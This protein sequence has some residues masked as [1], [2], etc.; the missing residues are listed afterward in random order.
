VDA[1]TNFAEV[2][3]GFMDNVPYRQ[4]ADYIQDL[5]REQG[6][7]DG[8][9]LELGCGTGSLTEL[10]AGKGY[11]MIGV[12]N[13]GDMLQIAMEKREVSGSDILYLLQDM[14]EFEL[15]G[16]VRAVVSICDSM[17][18][19]TEYEDLVQ[20]LRLVN[21]YLDPEGILIFDLNTEYKYR[22]VLGDNTI[23]ECREDKSFI[24]DNHYDNETGINQYD[25]TLFICQQGD[26]Y[27]RFDETHYQRAYGMEEIRRAVC[28]AGLEL[29]AMYDAFSREPIKEDSERVYVIAREHGKERMR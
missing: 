9:V 13:S 17:N 4:W 14:R 21:N 12:D 19:I 23:A 2:Y 29:V 25:L 15:Y 22:Q 7:R 6:I 1:Y 3:D 20:V 5:L 16:T 10:L 8:L 27:R 24:W 26:L 18:Y 28:E 11:D